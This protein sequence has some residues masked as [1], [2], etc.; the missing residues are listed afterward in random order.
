VLAGLTVYL[1]DADGGVYY[2]RVNWREPSAIVV[3][4]EARGAGR[5]A[6]SLAKARVTIPM[7]GGVESL[8]V[9]VATGI[10]LFEA[11][12]QRALPAP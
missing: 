12:R 7:V 1:A 6:E 10:L 11:A 8:N 9:A 4:G 2:D 5:E 3:G